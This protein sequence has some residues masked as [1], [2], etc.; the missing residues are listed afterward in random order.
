MQADQILLT[1]KTETT[2]GTDAA[3]T[4]AANAMLASNFSLTP[5]ESQTVSRD[6]V[7]AFFGNK[8]E[9]TATVFSKMSFELEVMGSG[10][11]IVPG[12]QSALLK[13]CGFAETI[14][15]SPAVPPRVQYDLVSKLFNS[16]TLYWYYQEIYYKFMGARASVQLV[17]EIDKI[18]KYKFDITGLFGSVT[19]ASM[20][21]GVVYTVQQ[22]L[23]VN[24]LNTSFDIFGVGMAQMP[25]SSITL[26]LANDVKFSNW[27]GETEV[28]ISGR[29][30][31]GSFEVKAPALS[32]FDPITLAGNGVNGATPGSIWIQHGTVDGKITRWESAI[33]GIKLK[34]PTHGNK[35]GSL[36]WKCDFNINP[37]NGNDEFKIITR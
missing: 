3:P 16:L 25:L 28:L 20:P 32:V 35:D 24:S 15:P 12:Q 9:T 31:S 36:T 10:T 29:S 11:A 7:R 8:D 23:I 30:P 13:S 34:K 4:V 19:D 33:G 1:A 22:P 6:I 2:Y 21:S 37:V 17:L 18:P 14:Y 27:V 5:V 26:N